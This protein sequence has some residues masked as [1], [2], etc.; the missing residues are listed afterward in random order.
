M[1]LAGIGVR[2][3]QEPDG[4][5]LRDRNRVLTWAQVAAQVRGMA[6]A[7]ASLSLD[8]SARVGVSG[9]NAAPTL[10]AHAAGLLAG[11][12]TVALHRQATITEITHELN[13]TGCEVVVTG[14]AGLDSVLSALPG[15]GVGTVVVHGTDA[16]DQTMAWDTWVATPGL[17]PDLANRP[18]QPLLVFTSG[19]TGRAGATPVS[20]RPEGD[21]VNA[22]AYVEA[23]SADS[24]F[25][26]GPHLVVGPLQ[27]TGPLTSL[28][29]LLSG[30][31]VIVLDRFDAEEVLRLID[32][33]R[34]TSTVMVPTHFTRLLALDQQVR[35]AHDV[36]SL[37]RVAH[38][39][40]ACPEDVKRAMIAWWGPVFVEAYGGSEVGTLCRIN[41]TDWLERPGSV[42][43]AVPPLIIEA[44]DEAGRVLPRG[45]TG[46]LGVTLP[47]G[48]AVRF[49][50]DEAKSAKAY[51]APG[52]ATLGDVGHVDDEGFVF[53]TD[54]IADMV[55]SGGVNLYPAECEQVLIRHPAVAEVAVIG[56]P[57][58]D[59]G[60]ALLALVVA[61][62]DLDTDELDRFCR[63][64]L[65]GYKCPR[66][67]EIVDALPRN[68]MGKLDK[69]AL[70]APYWAGERTI[71]G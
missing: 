33:H 36:R 69:R 51:L 46:I 24:G 6:A 20:W 14:P 34:V 44:Y 13:S 3:E 9:D 12:G 63:T 41:S 11:V 43:Q 70:R 57:D 39:G 65:A 21:D 52:I 64:E 54:R 38:T 30:R 10:V 50:G 66:S 48:R 67:Y 4:V 18:A 23:V 25:P 71:A 28:R 59:Y 26:A 37:E 56:V 68:E 5:A 29:H 27:H 42:G 1:Y 17:E 45:T 53:I 61:D 31:P 16:P 7:L 35:A 8:E 22:L 47:P 2:A 60:E 49:L 15:T 62:P 19:T 58:A 32:E 55:V 40:A